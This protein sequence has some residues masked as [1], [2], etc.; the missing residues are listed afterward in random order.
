MD[1]HP[2]LSEEILVNKKTPPSVDRGSL[3]KTN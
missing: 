3:K 1:M 2:R